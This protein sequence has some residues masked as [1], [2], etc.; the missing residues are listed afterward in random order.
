M[1]ERLYKNAAQNVAFSRCIDV[2]T[3]LIQKY[4]PTI[5]E[6]MKRVN[7]HFEISHHKRSRN[8]RHLQSYFK[9]FSLHKKDDA[10]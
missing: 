8:E 9:Y 6:E 5:L 7:G 1:K 2:M 10:A 3:R 4:G